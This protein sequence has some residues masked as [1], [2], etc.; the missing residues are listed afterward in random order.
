[1]IFLSPENNLG[2]LTKVAEGNLG[3]TGCPKIKYNIILEQNLGYLDMIK[4]F[5]LLKI[6][7]F[8]MWCI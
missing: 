3:L 4:V 7:P 6:F 8:V 2:A 1:M 5:V